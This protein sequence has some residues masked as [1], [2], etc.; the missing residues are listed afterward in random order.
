TMQASQSL[1]VKGKLLDRTSD[2]MH[3]F[4]VRLGF[5]IFFCAF[6]RARRDLIGVYLTFMLVLFLAV[7]SALIDWWN[8]EL[9]HGFRAVASV[10]AGT[11]ANRLAM[12]CLM[13][14]ACWWFWLKQRPSVIR[15]GVAVAAIGGAFVVVLATGSRSGLVGLGILGMLLQTSPR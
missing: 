12:I 3:D 2:M 10:T 11:N 4:W 9:A 14:M 1:G 13:E 7:P 6:V 8:G 5:L 15:W